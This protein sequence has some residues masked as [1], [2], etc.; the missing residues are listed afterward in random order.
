MKQ[1]KKPI[2]RKRK[3]TEKIRKKK[4]KEGIP[5]T[6]EDSIIKVKLVA[7]VSQTHP[8]EDDYPTAL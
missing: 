6:E 1:K 8:G 5:C 3:K 2:K 4:N 7:I